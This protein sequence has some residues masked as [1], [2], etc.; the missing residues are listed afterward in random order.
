M[1]NAKSRKKPQRI[2]DAHCATC[3]HEWL[4]NQALVTV[5]WCSPECADRWMDA[6][7]AEKERRGWLTRGDLVERLGGAP[8]ATKPQ[9]GN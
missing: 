3:T 5:E 8:S 2:R 4:T 1:A 7:P 9:G 6:H